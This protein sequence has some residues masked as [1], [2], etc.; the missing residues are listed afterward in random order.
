MRRPQF[1]RPKTRAPLPSARYP[2]PFMLAMSESRNIVLQ[3]NLDE[4]ERLNQLVEEFG[5]AQGLHVEEQYAIYLCLEEIVTNII[6]YAWP[7]GGQHE[8]QVALQ[9]NEQQISVQISDDG[10]PFDPTQMAEP[11]TNKPAA[12]RQIGGLGIHLVRQ[13]MQQM[14]YQRDGDKNVLTLRKARVPRE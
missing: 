13:T 2:L 11:D 8:I 14:E 3:N 12:E 6:N 10:M 9:V 1:N 7:E 4:L 5:E